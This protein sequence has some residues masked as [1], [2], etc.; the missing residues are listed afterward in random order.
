MFLS[1][2]A[3]SRYIFYFTVGPVYVEQEFDSMLKRG[4]DTLSRFSRM[5]QSGT[6]FTTSRVLSSK[7]TKWGSA[8]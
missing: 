2:Y 3:L 6:S 5:F 4:M 1:M 7:Q 8:F